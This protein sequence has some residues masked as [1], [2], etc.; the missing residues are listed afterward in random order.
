M[1]RRGICHATHL[2]PPRSGKP[3]IPPDIPDNRLDNDCSPHRLTRHR[4]TSADFNH[5]L[6]SRKHRGER[7]FRD[8]KDDHEYDQ[9]ACVTHRTSSTQA[10]PPWGNA[11]MCLPGWH[12]GVGK[13]IRIIAAAGSKLITTASMVLSIIVTPHRYSRQRLTAAPAMHP[14][15]QSPQGM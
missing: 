4:S 2:D 12:V 14:F 15:P 3:A 5:A 6:H 13:S 10:S 7:R 8:Y 1:L 11:T 9:Q